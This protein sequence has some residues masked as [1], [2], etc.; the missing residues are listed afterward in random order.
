MNLG[1]ELSRKVED[2]NLFYS[3]KTPSLV[4]NALNEYFG[5]KYRIE[6]FGHQSGTGTKKDAN[7]SEIEKWD[8]L[9]K[10]GDDVTINEFLKS[11]GYFAFYEMKNNN[12]ITLEVGTLKNNRGLI[13]HYKNGSD[14]MLYL[15]TMLELKDDVINF[16]TP[17]K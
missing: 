4:R 2:M 3:T 14:S 11:I 12:E 5:H 10:T 9:W 7:K 16:L 8:K 6:R 15:P 17:Q 1:E 13:W